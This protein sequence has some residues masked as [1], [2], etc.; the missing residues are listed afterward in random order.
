M[1]VAL[2]RAGAEHEIVQETRLWDEVKQQTLS[3]RKKVRGMGFTGAG[4]TKL[5]S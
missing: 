4:P 5:G 3:M 1:Q 2:A